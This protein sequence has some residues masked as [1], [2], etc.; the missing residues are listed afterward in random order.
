MLNARGPR[1]GAWV[2][3]PA[4][5]PLLRRPLRPLSSLAWALVHYGFVPTEDIGVLLAP[6]L[7][8]EVLEAAVEDAG[9]KEISERQS[10]TNEV[11]VDKKVLFEDTDGFQKALHT[12]LDILL[13]VWFAADERAEARA[14][15]RDDLSV[16]E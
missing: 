12:L 10:L 1:E 9:R 7:V 4:C 2:S 11:G 8:E 16:G 15:F 3:A 13:V 6:L 14:Y 5:P